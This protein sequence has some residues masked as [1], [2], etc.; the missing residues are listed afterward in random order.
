[1]NIQK[2]IENVNGQYGLYRPYTKPNAKGEYV[3]PTVYIT[4]TN[5]AGMPV[6]V[7]RDDYASGFLKNV[8]ALPLDS[9]KALDKAILGANQEYETAFDDVL[10][11]GLTVGISKFDK[12]FTSRKVGDTEDAVVDMDGISNRKADTPTFDVDTLPNF[13]V[14]KY[15]EIGWRDKGSFGTLPYASV[16]TGIEW[17]KSMLEEGVRKIKNKHEDIM[18]DGHA[19]PYAG[20]YIYGYCNFGSRNEQALTY[21]WSLIA[22]TAAEVFTDVELMRTACFIDNHVPLNRG[23]LYIHPDVEFQFGRDYK[24]ASERTLLERVLALSGIDAVRVSSK[25]PAAKQC[26]LVRMESSSVRIVQGTKG[27]IPI[28][29]QTEGGQMDRMSLISIQNPQMRADINGLTSITHGTKA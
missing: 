19:V 14:S 23:I 20:S 8:T 18:F 11:Y 7:K 22:T 28:M 3:D 29:W 21:D 26:V 17:D 12:T 24:A 15:F 1:M 2:A 13:V 16:D 9:Y 6:E 27:I 4:L 25:V 10:S 5:S